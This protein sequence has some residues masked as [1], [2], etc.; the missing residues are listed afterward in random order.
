MNLQMQIH[1]SLELSLFE[2]VALC[3][4]KRNN[5]YHSKH[6]KQEYQKKNSVQTRWNLYSTAPLRPLMKNS[7]K[8]DKEEDCL[9]QQ[10]LIS[11][12]QALQWVFNEINQWTWKN[13]CTKWRFRQGWLQ[14]N[15]LTSILE[16]FQMGTINKLEEKDSPLMQS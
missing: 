11:C 12:N 15:T 9:I 14:D 3:Y 6:L 13:S 1:R 16:C 2:P 8:I 4:W 10:N 5:T 7:N